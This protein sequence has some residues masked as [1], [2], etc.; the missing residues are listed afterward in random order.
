M[1]L[2]VAPSGMLIAACLA[3]AA[4]TSSSL[5][6]SPVQESAAVTDTAISSDG[7]RPVEA[8]LGP[9]RFMIPA[10]YY[11]SQLGPDFQG[12][13]RLILQWPDLQPL[14][15]GV[16]YDADPLRF[17]RSIGISPDYIDRVPL[18]TLLERNLHSDID[19]PQQA[20][21]DPSLNIDLRLRGQPVFG[22]QPYYLDFAK[23][24][25]YLRHRHGD[26]IDLAEQRSSP[27]NRD[28]FVSRDAQGR[29]TTLI[30]CNSREMADGAVLR[31]DTLELGEPPALAACEHQFVLPR[32][33]ALVRIDYPRV[34]L[35]DWNRIQTRVAALFDQYRSA[36]QT[37]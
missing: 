30:T 7:V 29:L 15:P 24:D 32:Y 20:R 1:T 16:R 10:N 19:P 25:V 21:E 31:G 2:A 35:Q 9:H 12:N 36:P 26:A 23:Y 11:D 4:C 33:R 13:L 5:P 28:W 6:S 27:L 18:E 22:L 34:F 14:P 17:N 8:R 3:L 37:D